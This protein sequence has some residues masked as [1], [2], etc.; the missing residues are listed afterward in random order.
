M[1]L[2][3]QLQ[4][5]FRDA[6]AGLVA[7]PGPYG[8]MVKPTQDPRHG[9]YQANCA[10]P[11][12][13]VLG[14]PPRDLA[15][16][17]VRRLDLGD[18]LEP[19]QVAGPGFINLRVRNDWLATRLQEMARDERLG[20]ERAGR[21]ETIVIDYSSPN[22]AKPMHVGHLRSTIIGD[23]LARL[24]R[25]L[26]HRV[27]SDNHLGDWGTQFGML[28]YG[29]KHFRDEAALKA[30]P[31]R[32]MVRLYVHVRNLTK[33]AEADEDEENGASKYTPEQ[34]AEA[35]RILEEVRRETARL[36]EGDEE[37]VRLWKEFMPIC[38][39]EIE[40]I[41]QRLDVR[42]DLQLGESFY[43]PMLPSV[44]QELL[45]KGIA[46][47]SEG[48]VAIFV[49]DKEGEP[50]AL[51]RKRDGAFTYTTT[52][53]ATIRYRVKELNAERILYVV[54]APQ[55]LHFKYL[56]EIARR[57][58]YDR[59]KFEHIAFGSVLERLPD[60]KTVM[61]R[62]R[63][64][65]VVEL[66]HL[67]DEAVVRAR[68]VYEKNRADRIARGEEVP[69][70]TEAEKQQVAE[71]VGIGAVKYADLSQNRTSDYVFDWD[72]MLAMDGNT[73]TYMQYAY[74]RNRNIFRKGGEDAGPFRTEP[75]LPSLDAPEE[76]AL[77]LQLLR[78][79]E[80]L[81]AA[82]ADYR[83]NLITAYLWDLAKV[84]S[85]FYEKCRVLNAETLALRRSRLLL[86]DLTA[87]VIQL[88]LQLLGIRTVERM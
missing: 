39:K 71:V 17:I 58:G 3:E 36:H 59:V 32:E 4:Q 6:L 12:A 84:Y 60:G 45:D 11:L 61:F 53:L 33:P 68:E 19:P 37:N 5:K 81:Q 38:M 85:K 14:R 43:N 20:V 62:T 31:V 70:L 34:V 15:Q 22:V 30:D 28:L 69:E 80:A 54:G 21:P 29:Y 48:A 76:R 77:A 25:F 1:T 35:R 46:Q 8:G 74:A 57:W 55:A 66:N 40:P 65:R 9:D 47:L 86:C 75:P 87:R 72:K 44:V 18:F 51:V 24:L 16:E 49:S 41:Y 88:C 83:P 78:L 13:K 42:F 7:D 63:G 52:D 79:G 27:I 23:A 73:A 10:M 82:A 67:L 26:G 56:F 50:P 64:G 2:L